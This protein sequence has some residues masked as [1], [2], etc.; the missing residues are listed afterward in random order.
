MKNQITAPSAATPELE[1][2]RKLSN[3]IEHPASG[4]TGTFA[5]K[6]DQHAERN[7]QSFT[8]LGAVDPKT[9]DAGECGAMFCIRFSDGA[10]VEAWPEEVESAMKVSNYTPQQ[11]ARVA[12]LDAKI[13]AADHDDEVF[14]NAVAEKDAYIESQGMDRDRLEVTG[15][16]VSNCIEPS[17]GGEMW[18]RASAQD[19]IDQVRGIFEGVGLQLSIVGSVAT[20][21]VSTK[22]LDLLAH[23]MEGFKPTLESA[24]ES[25]CEK[26]LPIH[27]VDTA[28]SLNP[29]P[30]YQPEEQTFVNLGLIDGRTI[31]LYFPERLFPFEADQQSQAD[32]AQFRP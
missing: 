10:E 29:L 4:K 8:V 7:G 12:E 20:Q 21:G 30:T 23:P 17:Q 15:R 24:L 1:T 31:E 22:D 25:I 6:Y 13:D 28:Q 27:T 32:T 9:Y 11:L 19:F 18:T 3:Y 5:A 14:F 16:E 26:F 2:E